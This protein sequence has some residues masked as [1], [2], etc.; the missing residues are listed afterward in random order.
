MTTLF[1]LPL[2]LAAGSSQSADHGP[3]PVIE[4]PVQA[5]CQ[6]YI[7][8]EPELTIRDWPRE[9]LEQPIN[10]YVV[11]S[12]DLDGSGKAINLKVTDSKPAG[13]FDKTTLNILKRTKF[14]AD[15]KANA[16]IYVRTYGT[17]KRSETL[18]GSL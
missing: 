3:P 16:C 18:H 13:I 8:H 6:E 15:A 7:T 14:S 5:T 12:Y 4:V 17:V 1:F 11:I 2:L 10:A 9:A